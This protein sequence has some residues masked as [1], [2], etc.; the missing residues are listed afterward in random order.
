MQTL[1]EPVPKRQ[2]TAAESST[3]SMLAA[4]EMGTQSMSN[5]G[6]VEEQQGGESE[7]QVQ[8]TDNDEVA[9]EA[10]VVC[11]TTVQ[12]ANARDDVKTFDTNYDYVY[13]NEEDEEEYNSI[14]AEMEAEYK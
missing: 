4:P 2:R 9:H 13:E 6:D 12:S 3:E 11:T 8:V 7:S 14:I 5:G 10:V 1:R